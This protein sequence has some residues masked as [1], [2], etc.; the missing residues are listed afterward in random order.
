MNTRSSQS[1][2]GISPAESRQPFYRDPYTILGAVL[3]LLLVLLSWRGYVRTHELIYILG[4]RR[5]A[6]PEFLANDLTWSVLPPTSF[7]FDHL[8]GPLCRFLSDFAIVNVGRVLTWFL[9]ASSLAMLA[10]TL[11]LPA[12][13]VAAGFLAWYLWGQTLASC[14]E[15]LQGFELKSLAYPLSYFSLAFAMRRQLVR[16]GL[17]AG[18]AT[19]FHIIVGG[20]AC[21]ALSLSLCLNR[22]LFSIRQITV[23]LLSTAPFIVPLVLA[24]GLFHL[25]GEDRAARDEIYVMF[26][27]PHCCDPE[28]FMTPMRWA[29]SIPVFLLTP[30]LVYFWQPRREGRVLAGFLVVLIFLFFTGLVARQFDLFAYL[31][32]YPFQLAKAIP[33]LLFFIFCLAYIGTMGPRHRIGKIAWVLGLLVAIWMVD[34]KDLSEKLA[35]SP[36]EFV[37][38]WREMRSRG[39]HRYGDQ[40]F[41]A[42]IREHTPR[43]AVFV[44]P[45]ILE[46]WTVAERA[47]TVAWRFAPLDARILEWKKRLDELNRHRPFSGKGF[48]VRDD[49]EFNQG[50]LEPAELARMREDYGATYYVTAMRRPE[51]EEELLY[52]GSRY[53]LYRIPASD[54]AK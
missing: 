24:V 39:P 4:P 51:L 25:G 17:C 31:K 49:L 22:R 16:A 50:Q 26:R 47:Q 38:E 29:F 52:E 21:L 1:K 43:D 40:E 35:E 54:G 9:T 2:G 48:E 7:L 28:T 42:W 36:G 23:F 41:Y 8:V 10:R 20:W 18:L 44:T 12:W 3:F 34:H 27:N 19:A 30:M 53:F 13:S 45:P 32:L 46:F 6:D 37:E 33:L 15:P 14:G 11:R 5:V